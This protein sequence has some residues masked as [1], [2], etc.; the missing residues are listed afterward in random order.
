[1]AITVAGALSPPVLLAI[2]RHRKYTSNRWWTYTRKQRYYAVGWGAVLGTLMLPFL[3]PWGIYKLFKFLGAKL[4]HK[5]IYWIRLLESHRD[6]FLEENNDENSSDCQ[7]ESVSA[8]QAEAHIVLDRGKTNMDRYQCNENQDLDQPQPGPSQPLAFLSPEA[9]GYNDGLQDNCY[10][11]ENTENDGLQDDCYVAEST[12]DNDCYVDGNAEDVKRVR[13]ILAYSFE[14]EDEE[15]AEVS[16]HKC[17]LLMQKTNTGRETLSDEESDCGR[18]DTQRLW[19]RKVVS[20]TLISVKIPNKEFKERELVSGLDETLC[21][22]HQRHKET[23]KIF[24][25]M[26]NNL[27]SVSD[28]QTEA[29]KILEEWK[30]VPDSVHSKLFPQNIDEGTKRS[31]SPQCEGMKDLPEKGPKKSKR[32]RK[33]RNGKKLVA[34]TQDSSPASEANETLHKEKLHQATLLKQSQL[35]QTQKST[36][37]EREKETE[38]PASKTTPSKTC[39]AGQPA[40]ELEKT[41][42]KGKNIKRKAR[43]PK[44]KLSAEKIP[45]TEKNKTEE[46]QTVSRG[47]RRKLACR[48]DLESPKKNKIQG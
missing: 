11:D 14:E 19:A 26:K 27:N 29:L 30:K 6:G 34:E 8:H 32:R 47:A 45:E 43:T 35:I 41:G 23:N 22:H 2:A 37:A 7:M 44:G 9:V 12:G 21:A 16:C 38:L 17:R 20:D 1:M 13:A 46:A 18:R 4:L 25:D 39:K 31:S 3:A 33:R 10:V 5:T 48:F 15:D 28:L 40:Q 24:N 36:E 42:E